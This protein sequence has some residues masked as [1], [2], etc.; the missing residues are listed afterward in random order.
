VAALADHRDALIEH[1]D[2]EEALLL[3][4]AARHLTV[5]EKSP[6]SVWWSR[7][8]GSLGSTQSATR[9]PHKLSALEKVSELRR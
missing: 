3:P 2:D 9:N 1:L 6:R 4:L 5:T 8:T 7:T